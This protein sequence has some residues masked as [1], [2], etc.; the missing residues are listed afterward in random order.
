MNPSDTRPIMHSL[1]P[2]TALALILFLTPAVKLSA[3]GGRPVYTGHNAAAVPAGTTEEQIAEIAGTVTPSARQLAWQRTEF[4]AFIHFGLNTFTGKEWGD[5]KDDPKI[6]NPSRLDSRQW[7]RT[8]RDAGMKMVILTARHHDGFCLWPTRTTAYSVAASP[9]K[10]GKGDVV[11]EVAASC[12]EYGLKFGVYLSPWD[13]HEPSY[14]T[15]EKYN[16]YFVAQLRELLTGYGEVSEVWFDGACG[17]GP[18]GKKQTY[19]WSAWYALVR[20]LQPGAVIAVMGP[21]VRWVG[22]ESGYGRETEWSVIPGRIR[23]PEALADPAEQDVIDREFLPGDLMDAD[24]GSREKLRA[25][26]SLSWYPAETDVSIRPGW[27]HHP[28]DNKK[29]KS[30]QELADI[31]FHSAGMNSVLL[32]NVPPDSR[33]LIH[34][35]D[36]RSL[37]GLRKI[38]NATF[39]INRVEKAVSSFSNG[40]IGYTFPTPETFDVAMLQEDLKAG[41]RIEK[42]SFETWDGTSWK[43]FATGTSVGNKRLLRFPAVTVQKV[44]L[45]IGETR[46]EPALMNV[47]LYRGSGLPALKR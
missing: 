8:F 16:G 23:N 3:Q 7:V 44:R 13:R 38:L 45:V 37:K 35:N 25:A 21:D 42:F 26:R 12:R 2:A 43:P 46:G 14:G 24:L 33:G 11:E 1:F 15:G 28:S 31:Y 20:E 47:G 36:I 39:K 5:G 32:L 29:V 17:E 34:K 27:F 4:N 41:Q 6:F 40:I 9:W 30:P 22:T 19:D 18:N 10:G